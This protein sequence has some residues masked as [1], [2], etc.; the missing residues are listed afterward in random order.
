MMRQTLLNAF[1]LA[2]LAGAVEVRSAEAVNLDEL[3]KQS[4][5]GQRLTENANT[6]AS[7]EATALE[8]RG[9][10]TDQGEFFFSIYDT[11]SR[12]SRWAGFNE[13]GEAFV[14]KSYDDVKNE[15]KIE[16]QG[17]EITVG[18]KQ[19]K[20]AVLASSPPPI[21]SGPTVSYA[22]AA[23]NSSAPGPAAVDEPTHL[24]QI[25]EEIRLRRTQRV[26]KSQNDGHSTSPAPVSSP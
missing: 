17:R 16:Y 20:A 12:S 13:T 10:F 14:V 9:V 19:A 2:A 1:I 25:A 11:A 7:A 6:S 15:A 5:F 8:L 24:A 3:L 21:P 23:A 22:S 18:L 4:P 26:Q